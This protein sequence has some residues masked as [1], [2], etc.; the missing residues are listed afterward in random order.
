MKL[1]KEAGEVPL[2]APLY[3]LGKEAENIL[4]TFVY[5]AKGDENR[6]KEVLD[7]L[8]RYFVPKVNVIHER[9]SAH[10]SQVRVWKRS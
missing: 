2:C 8:E 1:D 6:Y 10:Q 3:C 5:D 9:V 7:K 4:K